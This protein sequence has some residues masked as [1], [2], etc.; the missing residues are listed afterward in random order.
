LVR[1]GKGFIA[2]GR[3]GFGNAHIVGLVF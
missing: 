1:L 2:V 3:F